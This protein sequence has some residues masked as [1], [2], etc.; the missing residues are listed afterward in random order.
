MVFGV[1]ILTLVVLVLFFTY[2]VVLFGA[3]LIE[4]AINLPLIWILLTR[5]YLEIKHG[6]R[7]VYLISLLISAMIFIM[8]WNFETRYFIWWITQF[9]IVIFLIAQIVYIIRKNSKNK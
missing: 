1:E 8:L 6:R 5:V 9:V 3:T 4:M 7:D 2:L